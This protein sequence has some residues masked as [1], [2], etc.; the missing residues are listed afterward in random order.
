M[1]PSLYS[2][3]EINLL[4]PELRPRPAIRY[5]ALVNALVIVL[6]IGLIG[7]DVS[8]N[9]ARIRSLRHEK[10]TLAAQIKQREPIRQ[11]YL[12][13]TQIESDLQDY[14]RII[15]MASADY[16]DM[17]VILAR[18]AQLLP[19][20]VYLG[21]VTNQGSKNR[22][23][24]IQM[25][26]TLRS[27]K[28]DEQLLIQTLTNL[29]RDPILAD[30]YMRTADLTEV[31][32]TNLQDM[33]KAKWEITTPAEADTTQNQEYEF[34]LVINLERILPADGLVTVADESA[35]F[36]GFNLTPAPA[37]PTDGK[38]AEVPGSR[39]P[40]AV[41]GAPANTTVEGTN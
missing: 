37:A 8:F 38:A 24:A 2:R 4:P 11:D 21:K 17:P 1:A 30:C 15:T 32:I 16:V 29:K 40:P 31:P 10:Q 13:L 23:S 26:V 25:S 41:N 19:E 34:E 20:G 12:A 14:G 27:A 18:L 33:F 9:I 3:I 35:F 22:G 7:F 5:T 28:R 6:T 36:K 39:T